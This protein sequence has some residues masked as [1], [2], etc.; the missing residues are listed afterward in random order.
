MKKVTSLAIVLAMTLLVS[1]FAFAMD[2]STM[3]AGDMKMADSMKV[4]EDN[5]ALMKKDVE[6]MKDP[7]QRKAAMTSMNSH[8]TDL[9]H[10]MAAAEGHAKMTKN[11]HMEASMK[12]MNKEMMMTMKGMGMA[13]KDADKGI[14]MM[15][16]SLNK[17]EKTL[18]TMKSMM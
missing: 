12:Q 4:M 6:T 10:G 16:D 15:M 14:P 2:H 17:M 18:S 5:L 3:D 7:A 13:K 8:M 9:H 1:G 11:A